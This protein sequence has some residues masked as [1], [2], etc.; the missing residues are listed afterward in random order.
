[1]KAVAASGRRNIAIRLLSMKSDKGLLYRF[2][3]GTKI[4]K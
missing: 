1:M 3:K 4:E 2:I